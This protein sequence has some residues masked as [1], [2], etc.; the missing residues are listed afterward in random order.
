MSFKDAGP[1]REQ[2]AT[3]GWSDPPADEPSIDDDQPVRLTPLGKRLL[4]A[5]GEQQAADGPPDR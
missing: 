5:L 3:A 1:G 4:L 2:H